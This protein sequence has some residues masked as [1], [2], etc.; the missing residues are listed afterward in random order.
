V[1]TS[2]RKKFKTL[3]SEKKIHN[4]IVKLGAEI[5]KHY[6]KSGTGHLLVVGILKGSFIFLADIVRA[7]KIPVQ[8]DFIEVSSYGASTVSSG[9]IQLKRDL[10]IDISNQD[11]LIVEDIVDTGHTMTYLCE[12][13]GRRNPRSVKICSL[14]DK[15][16]R[17]KKPID[18]DFLG[19]TI[20]DHFVVGYGLDYNNRFR[21]IRSVVIYDPAA[22]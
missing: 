15:P 6:Q 7:I 18:V 1:K 16:S 20:E 9:S 22:E 8:I 14:L 3:L 11:V 10:E 5:T 17:R 21:E 12:M 4:R 19:F 13:L 2:D